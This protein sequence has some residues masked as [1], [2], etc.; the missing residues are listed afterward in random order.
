MAKT[1]T[2]KQVD[3]LNIDNK[4]GTVKI[5]FENGEIVNTYMTE[6]ADFEHHDSEKDIRDFSELLDV[7]CNK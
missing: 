5:R 3:I 1:I 2:G 7:Y 4:L 6:I